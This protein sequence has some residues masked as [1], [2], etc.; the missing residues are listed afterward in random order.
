MG[1]IITRSHLKFSQNTVFLPLNF[2]LKF[3]YFTV[4]NSELQSCHS[5]QCTLN[6]TQQEKTSSKTANIYAC[7]SKNNH[8]VELKHMFSEATRL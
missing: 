3:T 2:N 1:M 5:F 8:T 4:I 6:S 7:L